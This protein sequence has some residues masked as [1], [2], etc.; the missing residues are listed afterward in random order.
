MKKALIL[1]G[2]GARDPRW[3]EPFHRLQGLVQSQLPEATVSLA[4]LEL[5]SP[6]LPEEVGQLVLEGCTEIKV[7]PVF[8]GQGGHLLRDLPL[9]ISE[10][11]DRYPQIRIESARAVGEDPG[12]LNAIAH[13]CAGTMDAAT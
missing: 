9:I 10:L 13:Y 11:Q 8:F 4:F 7:V 5:M 1:F 12:V 3:A 6:T 2:H